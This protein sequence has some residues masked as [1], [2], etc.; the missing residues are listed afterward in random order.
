MATKTKLDALRQSAQQ[1]AY[2]EA[3]QASPYQQQTVKQQVR[4][5]REHADH[6]EQ[7][8]R[9][10]KREQKRARKHAKRVLRRQENARAQLVRISQGNGQAAVQAAMALMHDSGPHGDGDM[11]F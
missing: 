7:R 1:R 9:E 5:L 4:E 6:M 10:R 3:C 2:S 11:P 8:D